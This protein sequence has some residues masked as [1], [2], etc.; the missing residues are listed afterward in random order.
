MVIII[1]I[2]VIIVAAVIVVVVVIPGSAMGHP[3]VP[4]NIWQGCKEKTIYLLGSFWLLNTN[5]K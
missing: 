5:G 3:A 4:E 1:I 2:V